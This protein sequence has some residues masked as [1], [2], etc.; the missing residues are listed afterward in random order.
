MSSTDTILNYVPRN[1]ISR[2]RYIDVPLIAGYRLPI[3]PLIAIPKAGI[4]VSILQSAQGN[5]IDGP[6]SADILP[7]NQSLL[8][9]LRM[10]LY[11]ALEA[12]Y[13]LGGPY[14][15]S[16][17]GF[18]R[19]SLSD[20]YYTPYISRRLNRNGIKIGIGMNF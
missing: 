18:F 14:Y 17:E 8:P 11:L 10:D 5:L 2:I 1:E 7:I 12:T 3:G 19:R 9:K 15:L 20:E 4:I 6:G 13:P 16:A